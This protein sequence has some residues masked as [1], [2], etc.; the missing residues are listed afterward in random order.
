MNALKF[1]LIVTEHGHI[2]RLRLF[3]F[4]DKLRGRTVPSVSCRDLVIVNC[5]DFMS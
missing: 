1:N 3:R 2:V 5:S 4:Y